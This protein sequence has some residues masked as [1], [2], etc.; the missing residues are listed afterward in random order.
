MLAKGL[1]PPRPPPTAPMPKFPKKS[2]LVQAERFK[3]PKI[4][5]DN[6]RT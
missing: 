1:H 2:E 3:N 4:G 6:E 5:A